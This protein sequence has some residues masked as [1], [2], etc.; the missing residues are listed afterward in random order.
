MREFGVTG[1]EAPPVALQDGRNR[2]VVCEFPRDE[3]I[4]AD[5]C[6]SAVCVIRG[7]DRIRP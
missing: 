3:K 7:E 4:T 1:F 6:S 2:D 5:D